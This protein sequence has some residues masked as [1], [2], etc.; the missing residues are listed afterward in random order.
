MLNQ[1]PVCPHHIAD[2]GDVA[3]GG[4]VSHRYGTHSVAFIA[5]DPI[6]DSRCDEVRALSG[7]EMIEGA[8]A[9][10]LK[11]ETQPGLESQLVCGDLA[12]RVG[13][14][15]TKWGFFIDREIRW[16]NPAVDVS[17]ADCEHPWGAVRDARLEQIQRSSG[18]DLETLARRIPRSADIAPAG[19][20]VHDIGPDLCQQRIERSRVE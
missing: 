1:K 17:A 6:S 9:K 4:E 11:T 13:S 14:D 12:R 20:V 5:G 10:D 18:I 8:D 19:E 7:A 2:I 3:P 15:R 16:I